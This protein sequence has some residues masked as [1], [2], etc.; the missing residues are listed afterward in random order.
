MVIFF[1]KIEIPGDKIARVNPILIKKSINLLHFLGVGDRCHTGR[2]S[3]QSPFIEK[4]MMED[5]H[6]K[7]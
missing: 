1:E 7:Y 4:S 2:F 3:V 6:I 5:I